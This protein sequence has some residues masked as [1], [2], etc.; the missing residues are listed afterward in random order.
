MVRWRQQLL[1]EIVQAFED[2][3]TTNLVFVALLLQVPSFQ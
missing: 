1:N 3:A 2:E